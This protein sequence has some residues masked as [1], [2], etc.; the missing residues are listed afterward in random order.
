MLEIGEYV[1]VAG[2][3]DELLHGGVGDD[4]EWVLVGK[5]VVLDDGCS[6]GD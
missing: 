3:L 6:V 2:L 1:V 4:F 5:K